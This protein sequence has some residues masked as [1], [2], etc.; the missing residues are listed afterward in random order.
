MGEGGGGAFGGMLPRRILDL[1]C[2]LRIF[3]VDKE[4][5]E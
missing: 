1:D 3:I 2:I 4:N 5:I